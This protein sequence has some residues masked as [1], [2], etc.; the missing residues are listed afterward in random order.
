MGKRIITIAS[1]ICLLCSVAA[2]Q[3]RVVYKGEHIVSLGATYYSL[4][5]S[6]S[7]ILLVISDLGAKATYGHANLSYSY[8]YIPNQSI[9]IRA[10]W[11]RIDGGIDQAN[12]NLLDESLSLDISNISALTRSV[13]GTLF[14]RSYFGLDKKGNVGLYL[15]A[16]LS[17]KNSHSVIGPASADTYTNGHQIRASLAPGFI[18]YILPNAS[19]CAQIGIVNVSYN[20]SSCFENG[21]KKGSLNVWRGG[22]KFNLMD[23]MF[24]INFHF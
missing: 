7:D 23:L 9:G 4:G 24:G 17:Y 3:S 22:F 10:N 13:G 8:A 6:N 2:A 15:E 14:N 12:A 16:G 20:S 1:A 19:L 11:S 21:Q 5:S 18:L